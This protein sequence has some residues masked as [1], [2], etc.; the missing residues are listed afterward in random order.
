MGAD[1]G[2]GV[3]ALMVFSSF[4][5]SVLTDEG[6][7][8]GEEGAPKST[9]TC[10]IEPKLSN[11]ISLVAFVGLD[12]ALGEVKPPPVRESNDRVVMGEEGVPEMGEEG[13]PEMGEDD[14]PEMGDAG[15]AD[16]SGEE[17]G[18][19]GLVNNGVV[20]I[21]MGLVVAVP[22]DVDP[23]PMSELEGVPIKDVL[24]VVTVLM[25]DEPPVLVDDEGDKLLSILANASSNEWRVGPFVDGDRLG[26]FSFSSVRSLV[27]VDS[28]FWSVSLASVPPLCFASVPPLCFA[29]FG[30]A[31][32][33]SVLFFSSVPVGLLF[34]ISF[35]PPATCDADEADEDVVFVNSSSTSL[36]NSPSTKYSFKISLTGNKR[37]MVVSKH[38]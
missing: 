22:D 25:V 11:E 18:E 6:V 7:L 10:S 16:E 1:T 5:T 24:S 9:F 3:V 37:R 23:P 15:D 32:V 13:V 27:S 28:C 2:A 8:D 34:S 21:L 4:S 20:P 14:L 33:A 12:G 38:W 31:L 29:S 35:L 19:V 17:S 36:S 30:V 26:L